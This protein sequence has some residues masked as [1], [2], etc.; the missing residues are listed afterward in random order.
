MLTLVTLVA[1]VLAYDR[2]VRDRASETCE[3]RSSELASR[4]A[5]SETKLENDI[6]ENVSRT[7][8]Q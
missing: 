4:N 6:D 5:I 8:E 1:L 7:A 2:A 3:A